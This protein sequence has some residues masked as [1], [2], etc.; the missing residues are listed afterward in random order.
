MQENN[1]RLVSSSGKGSERF[2]VNV[3]GPLQPRVCDTLDLL[4][5]TPPRKDHWTRL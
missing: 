4:G 5:L 2:E 1:E 3:L